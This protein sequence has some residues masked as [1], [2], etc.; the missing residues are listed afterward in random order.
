MEWLSQKIDAVLAWFSDGIVAIFTA[1]TDWFKE[2]AVWV[3]DGILSAVAA[4][5]EAVPTPQ[6]MVNGLSPLFTGLPQPVLYL[7]DATGM[8][9]GL[10]VIGAGV[11]FNLTRKAFTLGQW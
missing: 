6:F 5:F 10:A 7:L 11:L 4:L 3:V 8:I 1:V 2:F 9:E